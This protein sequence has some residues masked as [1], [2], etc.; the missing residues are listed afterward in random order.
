MAFRV[1]GAFMGLVPFAAVSGLTGLSIRVGLAASDKANSVT[2]TVKPAECCNGDP[3]CWI[4][5]ITAAVKKHVSRDSEEGI[6]V[7]SVADGC[8]TLS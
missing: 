6:L 7:Q 2:I 4:D 5:T 1:T 8:L 3:C